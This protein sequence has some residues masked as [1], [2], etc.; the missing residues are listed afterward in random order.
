MTS[1]MTSSWEFTKKRS[2]YHFDKWRMDP[3]WDAVVGLGRIAGDWEDELDAAIENSVPGTWANR[4]YKGEGVVSPDLA[5]EEYDLI[6]AGA[7]PKMNIA[8]FVWKM[9]P[10]FQKITDLFALE[11]PFSRIHIQRTGEVFTMHIDKLQKWNPEHPENVF[12][13]A[14]H[15]NDWEPGQWWQSGN[16][17]HTKWRAGDI[18]TFDWMNLPHGTAN[19]SLFPRATLLLTGNATEQTHKFLAELKK[20]NEYQI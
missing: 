16:Y 8:H 5:A 19:A 10:K 15:L 4:G 7:D 18:F 3:R 14:I 17:T 20:V 13:C 9:T 2:I 6:K 11:D 12:R 1:T